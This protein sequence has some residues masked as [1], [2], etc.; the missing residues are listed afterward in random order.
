MTNLPKTSFSAKY[1]RTEMLI[2]EVLSFVIIRLEF[3][4]LNMEYLVS[5]NF[6]TLFYA[7]SGYFQSYKNE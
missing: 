5:S 3:I 1:F 7:Q 4:R 2:S 6:L